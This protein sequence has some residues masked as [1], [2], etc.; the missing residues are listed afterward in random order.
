MNEYLER[1][2]ELLG[3]VSYEVT[4]NGKVIAT[5][6]VTAKDVLGAP[7]RFTADA[8]LLTGAMQETRIRRTSG[9]SPLYFAAEAR[10]V[11]AGGGDVRARR[12]REQ[13]GG[14]HHG[15]GGG[16]AYGEL[17]IWLSERRSSAR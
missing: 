12:A 8:S 2:G 17:R 1:S 14:A 10:F 13:R 6:T 11:S 3:D 16:G 15:R 5:K 9:K 7:S 4:V